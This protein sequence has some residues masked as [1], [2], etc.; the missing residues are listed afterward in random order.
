MDESFP[1]AIDMLVRRAHI[2]RVQVPDLRELGSV[3]SFAA[4]VAASLAEMIQG[5]VDSEENSIA[6]KITVIA[7]LDGVAGLP[8]VT[9][10]VV[11]RLPAARPGLF[12]AGS[13]LMQLISNALK[14]QLSNL[15][16]KQGVALNVVFSGTEVCVFSWCPCPRARHPTRRFCSG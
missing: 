1:D 10:Q 5:E 16:C 4:E 7:V 2:R 6:S 15:R 13:L 8:K 3:R 14:V 11:R 9:Q 12:N